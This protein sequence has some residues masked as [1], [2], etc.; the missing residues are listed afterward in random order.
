[1]SSVTE[2]LKKSL[3][4][5]DVQKAVICVR[6]IH[7]PKAPGQD[8]W[9]ASVKSAARI[10]SDLMAKV[11]QSLAKSSSVWGNIKKAFGGSSAT[12]SYD[13]VKKAA[14]NDYIAIEV[15]FNPNTISFETQDS[16]PRTI[17]SSSAGSPYYQIVEPVSTT[18]SFQL[19][20]DQVTPL[21]TFM[22]DSLTVGNLAKAGIGAATSAI[23][24]K[25]GKQDE[26]EKDHDK[27]VKAQMD[28][29]LALLAMAETRQII[30]FWSAMCFRG[31]LTR[32]DSRYTV[33]NPDGTPV[34]GSMSVSIRQE[35]DNYS[36]KKGK[37]AYYDEEY[38][39]KQFEKNFKTE[40]PSGKSTMDKLLK[41]NFLN[42]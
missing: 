1:M 41:N 17:S 14:G 24:N 23:S 32:V 16:G 19:I 3:W 37:P 5:G 39:R 10:Q 12:V 30:F 40:K 22:L 26:A 38:W 20:F 15:Q 29:F 35:Q 34:R 33:F 27:S 28:G 7:A 6:N 2:S 31:E 11:E 18:M 36:D 21:S 8:D 4:S 13:D 25:F 9:D 42:F